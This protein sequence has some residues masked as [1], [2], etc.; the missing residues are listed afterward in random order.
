MKNIK[1]ILENKLFVKTL[2]ADLISNFGDVVYYI[3]L[4]TYV[5]LLPES[6]RKFAI[7]LMTILGPIPGLLDFLLGY[8]GDKTKD[9][10]RNILITLFIRTGL[11]LVL[12]F[13]MGFSPALWIVILAI[14]INLFASI[15]GIYENNLYP[16][17]TKNIISDEE[18]EMFLAFRI[19]T[20]SSSNIIF[21][22]L[23]GILILF[24][25]YQFLAFFNALTFFISALI[26]V[27]IKSSLRKAISKKP[28][29]K[30]DSKL[31]NKLRDELNT[32][33]N[34]ASTEN[35]AEV[36]ETKKKLNIKKMLTEQKHA[37]KSWFLIPE[38]RICVIIW[39]FIIPLSNMITKLV[40]LMLGVH[41]SMMIVNSS[42]TISIIQIMYS[43][44]AL[45]GGYVAIKFFKNISITTLTR[46]ETILNL[47]LFVA[48][49]YH[50]I[51]IMLV[52]IVI[53]VIIGVGSDSKFDTI[54]MNGCD[55]DK[56]GVIFGGMG[57]YFTLGNLIFGIIFG[58][59]ISLVSLNTIIL[60]A[61]TMSALLVI[62]AWLIFKVPESKIE[63]EINN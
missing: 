21:Q 31:N 5:T 30:L 59:L 58:T 18:R 49:Y 16:K 2:I 22:A 36:E 55:E 19:S 63:S 23:G 34:N 57:T 25:S 41:S 3:A 38:T 53:T 48:L 11:Y 12:G 40:V 37:F 27:S 39:P 28:N 29:E 15:V 24:I 56:L 44:G 17:I 50:Q 4:M 7:S 9:K 14:I 33:L 61:I 26:I 10:I 8:L 52:I 47:L 45:I 51:Y 1:K 20:F 42:F 43:L 35:K 32:E 6:D 54:I 62:Y 46:I 13:T 60:I